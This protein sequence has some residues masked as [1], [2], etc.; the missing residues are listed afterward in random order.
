MIL[1]D[2]RSLVFTS[3]VGDDWIGMRV[4]AST[5]RLIQEGEIA[6]EVSPNYNT[7]EHS[8]QYYFV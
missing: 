7:H 4:R 6:N 1:T 2:T 8:Y 5:H 3:L